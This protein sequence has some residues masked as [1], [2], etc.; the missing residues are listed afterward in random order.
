MIDYRGND[1]I[2]WKV[3]WEKAA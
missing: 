3:N 2:I 1:E